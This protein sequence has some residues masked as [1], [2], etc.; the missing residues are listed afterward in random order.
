M[1][2]DFDAIFDKRYGNNQDTIPDQHQHKPDD[3]IPVQGGALSETTQA[4]P[5]YAMN[6][7]GGV[8]T[9]I[10]TEAGIPFLHPKPILGG[11]PRNFPTGEN[12]NGNEN[13]GDSSS[14]SSGRPRQNV[15][16]YKDSPTI[17]RHLPIDDESYELAYDATLNNVCLHPIPAISN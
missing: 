14:I 1:P 4:D 3:S 10:P 5:F 16:A 13:Q 15:G 9:T 17:T 7:P 6:I 12:I 8:P 11:D 2:V